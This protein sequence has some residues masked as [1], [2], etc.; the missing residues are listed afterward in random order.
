MAETGRPGFVGIDVGTS[1]CKAVLLGADGRCAATA[2][3]S[4]PT[5]RRV[6]G[7][8]TQNP[9]DW[10]RAAAQVTRDCTAAAPGMTVEALSVTGPAHAAA[11]VGENGKVLQRALLALDSRPTDVA[12]DLQR[13]LGASFFERTRVALTPGWT[14]P[15]LAWLRRQLPASEWSRIRLV[16]VQKDFVRYRMTGTSATDPSD[17][18]GTAMMDQRSLSWDDDLVAE[19]GI[20]PEALP[21]IESA[22]AVGGGLTAGWARETGLRRGTPVAIGGTDTVAELISLDA[23]APGD[24]LVKIASTGTVVAVAEVPRPHRLLLT[25]PHGLPGLWY[26]CAAT[27]T[28]A[29]AFTWLRQLAFDAVPDRPDGYARITR[30][31]ARAPAG[32]AGLIFLP[33]L[34]GERCPFW[35]SQLRGAFLGLSAAHGAHHLARSVLEGV[36][37][38]LRSCRDLMHE[39]GHEVRSP[40]LTG[41]GVASSL[42]RSI[43]ASALAQKGRLADPQG[44]GVGAALIAA[45]ATRGGWDDPDRLKLHRSVRSVPA[46]EE[47]VETY[48]SAYAIYADAAERL[49]PVSH[50]LARRATAGRG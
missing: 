38:S 14:L 13:Q 22:F 23:V 33:F 45:A 26:T 48:D 6:D 4:Y 19:A 16:L 25:Y 30:V 2:W 35:D 8:V 1:G 47:W 32:S 18:A 20:A 43:L 36:A 46:R 44:P 3:R 7:E 28:A 12:A 31:A 50:E 37:Y 34:D 24:S 42:W 11:L 15:Q 5:R 41:G 27:N 9:A 49:T 10:L 29:A 40:Y 17:A 39:T 21:P